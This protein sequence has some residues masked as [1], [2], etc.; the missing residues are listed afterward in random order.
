[1]NDEYQYKI[2]RLNTGED[3]IGFCFVDSENDCVEIQNPMKVFIRRIPN[4]KKTVLMM[5]PWLPLEIV[6]NDSAILNYEDILTIVEPKESFV[7]YYINIL[8]QYEAEYDDEIFAAD[9]EPI[10]MEELFGDINL[11]E[12]EEQ[13]TQ[14]IEEVT[15]VRNKGLL[16]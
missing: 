16:H 10:T 13:S 1:M 3:I 7:E 4:I 12:Y 6:A 11:D 14:E 9:D 5:L 2:L 8:S 15:E